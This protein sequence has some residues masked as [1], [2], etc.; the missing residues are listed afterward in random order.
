LWFQFTP[1]Q[2]AAWYNE[3]NQVQ[4]ILPSEKNGMGLASWRSERTASVGLRQDGWVDFGARR[5]DGKQDGGDALELTV[6]VSQEAKQEV[7]REMA[8]QLVREAREAM[9]S[10]AWAGEPPP[11]WVQ[12]FMSP[13]GWQRYR[14]LQAEAAHAAHNWGVAGFYTS[15]E[16]THISTAQTNQGLR[17]SR[18]SVQA[19][20]VEWT[21]SASKESNT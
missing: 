11:A 12:P 2:L 10:A 17:R 1:T 7:M 16:Q 3:R 15:S 18:E 9:E 5:A 4:D 13:A 14:A 8:R 19:A 6:R 20:P 21:N